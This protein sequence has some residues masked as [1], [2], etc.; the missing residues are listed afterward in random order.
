[1]QPGSPALYPLRMSKSVKMLWA[2]A[3]SVWW[4]TL[5]F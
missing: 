4:A 5:D 1:V 3:E 2:P